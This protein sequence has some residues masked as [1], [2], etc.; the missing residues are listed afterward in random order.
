MFISFDIS[1][2]I[3]YIGLYLPGSRFYRFHSHP[4]SFNH[5]LN[6]RFGEFSRKLSPKC[7]E[8]ISLLKEVDDDYK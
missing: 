5:Q 2:S 6:T 8:C 7:E 1:D 3:Y 4:F